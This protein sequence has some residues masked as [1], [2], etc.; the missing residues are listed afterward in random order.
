M[1]PGR[2]GAERE[3]HSLELSLRYV[4]EDTAELFRCKLVAFGAT[5]Q[6]DPHMSWGTVIRRWEELRG[7]LLDRYVVTLKGS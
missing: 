4:P 1:L 7:S 6:S 2:S 5:Q 3:P